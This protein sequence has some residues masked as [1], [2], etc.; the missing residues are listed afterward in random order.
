MSLTPEGQVRKDMLRYFGDF[1]AEVRKIVWQ[2]RRGAPDNLLMLD[3][4]HC[5][6]ETKAP[7]KA[8]EPHQE[9]ELE[10]L[11]RFGGFKVF[12]VDN[13]SQFLEVLTWLRSPLR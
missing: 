5:F 13:P 6:V 2:G 9:R 10:R 8:L 4:R 3:G 1:G 12:T 11:R 7:G